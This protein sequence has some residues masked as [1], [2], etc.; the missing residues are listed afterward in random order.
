[1]YFEDYSIEKVIVLSEVS[2]KW[3]E[4]FRL[5]DRRKDDFFNLSICKKVKDIIDVASVNEYVKN[6]KE[7]EKNKKKFSDKVGKEVNALKN[8]RYSSIY[9]VVCLVEQSVFLELLKDITQLISNGIIRLFVY[10]GGGLISF[11]IMLKLLDML[12]KKAIKQIEKDALRQI[13]S[14]GEYVPEK[15]EKVVECVTMI[16]YMSPLLCL[17]TW[18][19]GIDNSQIY[20][21]GII[22]LVHILGIGIPLFVRKKK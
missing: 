18:I 19:S 12:V 2:K 9:V 7:L 17:S 15:T 1:M 6:K 5:A 21:W 20:K 4:K 10:I 13:K 8:T 14:K 22:I 16:C 11:A 3:N